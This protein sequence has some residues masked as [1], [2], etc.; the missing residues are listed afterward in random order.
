MLKTGSTTAKTTEVSSRL[1]KNMEFLKHNFL[2]REYFKKKEKARTK[3]P[4]K[5][6]QDKKY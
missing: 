3:V 2:F 1:N 4:K 5:E 6:V